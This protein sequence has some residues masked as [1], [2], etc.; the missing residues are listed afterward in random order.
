MDEVGPGAPEELGADG[1]AEKPGAD[2]V[3]EAAGPG[4]GRAKIDP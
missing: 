1:T 4:L 2:G 3:A